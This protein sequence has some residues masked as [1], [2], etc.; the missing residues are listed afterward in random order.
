MVESSL[1]RSVETW[2]AK[3]RLGLHSRG[4]VCLANL[5]GLC[6]HSGGLWRPGVPS[7]IRWTL[8]RLE[9]G[10]MKA[11]QENPICFPLVLLKRRPPFHQKWRV[12]LISSSCEVNQNRNLLWGELCCYSSSEVLL[13]SI[14]NGWFS[15]F[16][17]LVDNPHHI[18]LLW[19]VLEKSRNL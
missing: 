19:R 7:L 3:Q 13:S 14:K 17:P 15:S 5:G 6:L 4:L 9:E 16:P 8:E 2:S 10:F 12:S 18:L 11:Q 1:L